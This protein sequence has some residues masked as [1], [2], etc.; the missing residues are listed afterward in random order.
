MITISRV[1]PA[2]AITI[3]SLRATIIAAVCAGLALLGGCGVLRFA[4]GQADAFAFRWLDGYV[5]FDGPQERRVREALAAWF[6]WNRRTQLIDYAALLG[7]IE[8]TVLA[9][10]TPDAVCGWWREVRERVDVGLERAVPPMT[11]VAMT[12][13]PAQIVNVERRD[14]KSNREFRENFLQRDPAD[15]SKAA[16]KRVVGRAESIYGDVDDAQ[17]AR[18]GA[19]LAESPFDSQ[20]ALEERRLRQRDAVDVLRRVGA[21]TLDGDAAQAEIRAYLG[22]VDPSP[23]AAYRRYAEDLVRFNCRLAA[24][25]HNGTTPAQRQH[26]SRKLKGWAAELRAL[27]GDAAG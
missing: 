13:T 7:R 8:A 2:L 15:R 1:L 26:A 25:I 21:G 3:P 11:E 10:T 24:D 19:W 9:D 22:R 16:L 17:R 5:H 23:R 14:T 18:I 12:L 27:A 6:S 20:R 4:Y